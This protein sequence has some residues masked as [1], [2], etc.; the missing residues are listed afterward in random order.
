MLGRDDGLCLQLSPAFTM[1][2]LGKFSFRDMNQ[3]MRK[4]R[5]DRRPRNDIQPE[6]GNSPLSSSPPSNNGSKGLSD[7]NVGHD[8][9]YQRKILDMD[10]CSSRASYT[11][12][13]DAEMAPDVGSE[14][15]A[16]ESSDDKDAS[17]DTSEV[18][19]SNYKDTKYDTPTSDGHNSGSLEADA[20]ADAKGVDNVVKK[21]KLKV[22]GVIRTIHAK[23]SADVVASL[24][25]PQH[26]TS[27]RLKQKLISQ[28]NLHEEKGS[29]LRGIPWKDFSGSGFS[30]GKVDSSRRTIT[31]EIRGIKNSEKHDSVHKSKRVPRRR[32]LDD[33][34]NDDDEDDAELRYLAK[35]RLKSAKVDDEDE[36]GSK[37]QR[38]I[39]SVLKMESFGSSREGKKSKTGRESED[40]DYTGE[41]RASG[42]DSSREMTVT[43]RRQ[44][45]HSGRDI[46]TDS[47]ASVVEFPHGLPPAPPRKQKDKLSEV[48]HQLKKAE[49]T[50]RRKLQAAKAARE[51]E[52]RISNAATLASNT[53]RWVIGPT[54]T[55]VTFSDDIGLPN[56]FESKPCSYPPPREK[57]AGPSCS[58]PF[59]YRDS[60]SKLPLCSLQCYNAVQEKLQARDVC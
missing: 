43:T 15:E 36:G 24:K 42:E 1:E 13:A 28:G 30:V 38:K 10:Q 14:F 9:N 45:L 46:S 52:E 55:V 35:M 16:Q 20:D 2:S 59:K 17:L 53:V 50:Q 54:Q 22:G 23:P 27:N 37:K 25:P 47:T 49:A 33:G 12:L 6:N 34:D 56:I 57:C 19:A 21:V 8:T 51:S 31:E 58:E 7:D 41:E 26:S 40:T 48:E 3:T 11:N 29:G 5:S 44:A 39:S 18:F 32:L 4:K 60:R